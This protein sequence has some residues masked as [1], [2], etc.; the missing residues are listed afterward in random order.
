MIF[1]LYLHIRIRV[2]SYFRIDIDIIMHYYN[3]AK[4]NGRIKLNQIDQTT[5]K[6]Q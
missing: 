6:Y 5:Q 4:I 3:V 1:I 2:T